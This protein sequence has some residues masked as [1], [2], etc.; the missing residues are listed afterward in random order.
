MTAASKQRNQVIETTLAILAGG[1]SSRMG[2]DKAFVQIEGQPLIERVLG[3]TR[4]LTHETMIIANQAEKFGYLG[5]PCYA[6]MIADL[7]PLGGIYTALTHAGGEHVL[8]VAVDMPFLNR[9]L[10]AYLLSLRVGC[11]IVAP[12]LDR[13]PQATHA[14]YGKG[15]LPAIRASIEAGV[16]K[17]IGFYRDVRVR[18]VDEPEMLPFDPGLRSFTNVNT[19]DELAQ[20]GGE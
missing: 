4:G 2:H 7:G 17:V 9:D 20:F 19:P 8:V 5:L 13:Y 14:V 15:C 11:D 1:K 16:L 18:T 10:L 6:D 12:R 3:R